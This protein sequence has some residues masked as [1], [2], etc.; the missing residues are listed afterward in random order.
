MIPIVREFFR[1][2]RERGELDDIIPEL[3]TAMGFEVI[4]RPMIGTRQYGADVAAIGADHDGVRK[5]FLFV[6]KKGDLTRDEW[7]GS[8][9][10]VR[11]SLNEVRDAYLLGVAPEHIGLPVVVCITI[12]GIVF[13]N[14]QKPV[15]GYMK[16]ESK[17]GVEFRLWTGDTL[18]GKV[19]DGALREEVFP[20]AFRTLLRRAAA[21]VEEPEAA[22][23]QFARLVELVAADE[24]Q[25]PVSRVRILYLALW[26]LRVWAREAN[27]LE[28]AYRA[29]E[30]VAL[31][32]WALLSTK[33]ETDRSRKRSASQCFFEVVQLHLAIWEE[34]YAQKVLPHSDSRH[35]LS[36]AAWSQ[37]A[38]D[39][40][41]ALFETVGRIAMGGLWHAWL[42]GGTG[43]APGLV[44]R[45]DARLEAIAVALANI[46]EANPALY[47]PAC[48][49]HG[50]DITLALMLLGMVPATRAAA[51]H[52]VSQTAHAVMISYRRG[53]RYP[54]T[55]T[56][57]A[58]LINRPEIP[59]EA[60]RQELTAASIL[61]PLLAV[62]AHAFCNAEL[63]AE[64][65]MF[66]TDDL[67]HSNL[68]T[69]V[70]NARSEA[71]IWVGR[72]NGST[73]GGL[74]IGGDGAELLAALRREVAQ[75][76]AYPGLSAIKLEHW[77]ML[78][79]ACRVDRMPPPP[80]MWLPLVD[81]LAAAG[82]PETVQWKQ[83]PRR[84]VGGVARARAIA[85]RTTA[86]GTDVWSHTSVVS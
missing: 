77:P 19:V 20:P 62:F 53:N 55:E 74:S 2:L 57:Y 71:R 18:T 40:N 47:T 21:L 7:D 25:D 67:A 64:L 76:D 3:L 50:I 44:Q 78:L 41:L 69:W 82:R 59:N 11:P 31:R 38:L 46:V 27:N 14:V 28:A 68:Q 39:I 30:L 61:Q 49:D 24:T 58:T 4:S 70:P 9:Q 36:Y 35:A 37:E 17:S 23:T 1:G 6:I 60:L 80:Q 86:A 26:I 54:V 83:G 22:F 51:A 13:E 48:E 63:V 34:L 10:A 32:A 12:G 33:I 5:L 56:D 73:L 66:Q 81:A 79:L 45:P 65:G 85:L 42:R 72:R 29:S 43:A 15:N 16:M 8:P 52:W 84:S 75:N